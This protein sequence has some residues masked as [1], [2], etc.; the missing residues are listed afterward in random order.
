M[1]FPR[2][3]PPVPADAQPL[4]AR[5]DD[6][7]M[8]LAQLGSRDA[9]AALVERYATRV[10]RTCS[11]FTGEH[12]QACE[13]AQGIW[14]TIWQR[15]ACY[16]PGSDFSIWL[17]TIARNH[18]RNELRRQRVVDRYTNAASPLGPEPSPGQID[19]VLTEERRRRVREALSELPVALSEALLMRFGEE[20][21]YDEMSKVLGTREST[22][23]SRVHYG[24]K[25]LK[26]KL[27]KIV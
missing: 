4:G 23:R 18:C 24:L 7:L 1:R 27:E 2:L 19:A 12:D 22:L 3:V 21:R 13:L 10:V 25:V 6:T 11:R 17:I 26:R 8:T 16:Q 9:F 15:R 5:D 14:A 20:L